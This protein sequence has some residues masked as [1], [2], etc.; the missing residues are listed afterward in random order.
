MTSSPN[1]IPDEISD[2]ESLHRRIHPTHIHPD[3][4]LSSQSFRDPEMSVD[5]ADF[6]PVEN[7]LQGYQGCGVAV[8]QAIDARNLGQEV[9]SKKELLNP[10]HAVVIGKKPKSIARNL[11]RA[12]AWV[13]KPNWKMK[14]DVEEKNADILPVPNASN[15]T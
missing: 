11:A 14:A 1:E 2:E 3:G 9:L 10:A 4:R 5:R 8:L 13:L 7:T 6:W 15:F 12:A